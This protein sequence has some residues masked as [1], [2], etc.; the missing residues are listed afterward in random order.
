VKNIGEYLAYLQSDHW[1]EMRRLALEYADY[2]CQLCNSPEC[3]EVHHRTYERMG[4][5]RLADLVA[6]CAD[7][8]GWHH[9]RASDRHHIKARGEAITEPSLIV[10]IARY[11]ALRLAAEGLDA[12]LQNG[13]FGD[14]RQLL[15][16]V[17]ADID[18]TPGVRPY[19]GE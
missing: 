13:G 14:I 10:P 7:C 12:V 19:R 8:H 4:R 15:E 11:D 1:K 3:L 16:D 6:L 17:L 5:E 18:K 9:G 2:R